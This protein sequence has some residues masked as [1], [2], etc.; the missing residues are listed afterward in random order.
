TMDVTGKVIAEAAVP[1]LDI[2]GVD[3]ALQSFIGRIEQEIPAYSA[4]KHQG[5]RL[6]KLARAGKEVPR[7]YKQVE[8]DEIERLSLEKDRLSIRVVCGKGT[9][10]RTLARDIARKLGTAGYVN[11]LV[12]T[13]VGDYHLADAMTIEAVQAAMKSTEVSQ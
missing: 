7:L 10:I 9:Y 5:K 3:A 4:A 6:Y 8:I 11:T 1:E 12:R 13:R 2:A